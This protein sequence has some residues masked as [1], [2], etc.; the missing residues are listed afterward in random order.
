MDF[1]MQLNLILFFFYYAYLRHKDINH[2][3]KERKRIIQLV[4]RVQQ[5]R[6]IMQLLLV[7]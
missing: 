5:T 7:F 3:V 2:G 4:I 1:A 6:M